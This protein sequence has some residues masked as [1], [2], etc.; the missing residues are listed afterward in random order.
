MRKLEE[1]K[2]AWTMQELTEMLRQRAREYGIYYYG[3]LAPYLNLNMENPDH[4]NQI[5][6]ILGD[7]SNY[8]HAQG[9]PLLSAIVILAD[10]NR[11]GKGFFDLARHL[12]LYKGAD[13]EHEWDE[14]ASAEMN[15]VHEYWSQH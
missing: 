7:V 14:Y 5:G 1:K 4:R 2:M 9:R 10:K 12:G 6:S 3:D 11:P 8:E 13:N 15:R